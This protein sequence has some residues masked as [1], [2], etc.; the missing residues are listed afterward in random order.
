MNLAERRDG[1]RYVRITRP[2]EAIIWRA[3]FAG[4]YQDVFS[5]PPYNERFFPSEAESVLSA[6]LQ[7]PEHITLLAIHGRSKIIGFGIAVPLAA[8]PAVL[9]S[10]RGLIPGQ[11]SFYLA[12]LGVLEGWRGRGVGRDLVKL[13][14]GLIDAQRYSHAT[15]RTSAIRNESYEMYMSM[16]FDDMGVYME[17]PA[18]RVDGTVSTDRRLFLSKVLTPD[19]ARAAQLISSGSPSTSEPDGA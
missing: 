19:D 12:D 15:L 9:S 5:G 16:G 4:C 11:H 6:Y 10:L 1:I 2:E 17:V 14:L 8:R 7:T 18:R 3:A 13:R